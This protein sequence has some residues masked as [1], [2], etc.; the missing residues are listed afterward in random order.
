[1]QNENIEEA[2]RQFSEENK[3]DLLIIIPK[4]HGLFNRLLHE[5]HSKQMVVNTHIPVMSVHG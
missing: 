3:L 2:I 5:S 1:M 4:K